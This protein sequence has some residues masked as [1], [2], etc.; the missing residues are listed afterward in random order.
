MYTRR[1]AEWKTQ[2]HAHTHQHI[3]FQYTELVN[4]DDTLSVFVTQLKKFHSAFVMTTHSRSHSENMS[5]GKKQHNIH[6]L[7]KRHQL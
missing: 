5:D 7:R 1:L 4:A 3:L 6:E 2:T